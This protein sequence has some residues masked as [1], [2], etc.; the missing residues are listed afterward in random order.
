MKQLK[1]EDLLAHGITCEPAPAPIFFVP[2][3]GPDGSPPSG[4]VIAKTDI[5]EF[6]T[7]EEAYAYL[8]SK[9]GLMVL[10][11]PPVW[12]T[13]I[14]EGQD[15]RPGVFIKCWWPGAPEE[16][17]SRLGDHSDVPFVEVMRCYTILT[18]FVA[19]GKSDTEEAYVYGRRILAVKHL[20]T[21]EE[22][23]EIDRRL[24][25]LKE[26]AERCEVGHQALAW[27]QP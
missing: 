20:L 21:Q 18:G 11:T 23:T 27:H 9:K 5:R 26:W 3:P 8:T 13:L 1:L 16:E 17:H 24:P 12:L 25:I 22:K 7:E 15:Y 6:K 14:A 4:A 19:Q 10:N 2:P